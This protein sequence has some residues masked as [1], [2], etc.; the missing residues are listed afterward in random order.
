LT[1]RIVRIVVIGLLAAISQR[2]LHARQ[3]P[4]LRWGGD[5][6]G[7]APYVEADP[8]DPSRV[9]GF[10]VEVAELVAQALGR[11]PRFVQIAFTSLDQSAIRGDF[12][13]GLS[14]IEDTPARRAATAATIP[15]YEF[16]EVLTVRSA[17]RDRFRS[18]ADLRGRRVA[19]L[20]GTIAYELLLAAE[21]EHGLIPRAYDDDVGAW[22]RSCST[23]SW[24]TAR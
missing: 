18:L 11:T 22:T 12:D 2:H 8:N 23:T 4:V 7:G 13:L 3:S 19:T 9:V 16:K 17:D 15:Y 20:A 21:K 1:R 24:P 14:G 5:A 10:D 6:Q